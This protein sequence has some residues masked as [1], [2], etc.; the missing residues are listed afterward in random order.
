M[1]APL[2]LIAVTAALL[3][4]RG[5]FYR[6][7]TLAQAVAYAFAA[8]GLAFGRTRLGRKKIFAL[9]AFFV[10]VNAASVRALSNLLRGRTIDR[11]EPAREDG[12]R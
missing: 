8:V 3:A 1:A 4:G 5:R 9:P 6:G 12:G 11:W 2:A 7:V 10:L